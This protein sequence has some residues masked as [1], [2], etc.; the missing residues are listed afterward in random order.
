MNEVF[1]VSAAVA[2]AAT[3]IAITRLNAVHA[4]LNLIVSLLAVAVI[5]YVLGAPFVAALEVIVYAG[6]IMVLFV[7]VVMMIGLTPESIRQEGR[8][9]LSPGVLVGPSILAGILLGEL[10]YL[11]T[12]A[13]G[14]MGGVRPVEPGEFGLALF[15]PY[16]LAVELASIILLTGLIGA[17]HLGHRAPRAPGEPREEE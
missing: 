6:A 14:G 15:G 11:V 7:F 5:F 16:L 2:V 1:Y 17:Y 3:L 4:L 8:W 9:F 13:D 12:A 10:I